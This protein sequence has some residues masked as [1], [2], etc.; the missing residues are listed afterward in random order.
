MNKD[1]ISVQPISSFN[2][3]EAMRK[4]RRLFSFTLELSARCNLNCRHCYLNVPENDLAAQDAELSFQEITALVDESSSLGAL[5]ALVTGGE[6]LLRHDFFDIYMYL[7][8]KGM[9][10]SVF[11]NATLFTKEH[12][13][14][15]TRYPPRDLDITVYGAT[16][17]TYERI[18]RKSGS[19]E[20]FKEGIA[21]L[22][23][24]NIKFNLKAM[25]LRSN[26]QEL[27]QITALCREYSKAPFRFDPFLHL[28]FDRDHLRNQ[29]IRNERLTPQEIG[30][31]ETLDSTRHTALKKECRRLQA[32]YPQER[33][34]DHLFRCGTGRGSLAI[35]YDGWCRMC[36]SL[37]HP[38]C[39]FDLRNH[40][41]TDVWEGCIPQAL[42]KRVQNQA[43]LA[44]CRNCTFRYLCSWCPAQSY[45]EAG[46]LDSL[47]PYL[48]DAAGK[49]SQSIMK[50]IPLPVSL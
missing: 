2:A 15:F 49:R 29:E 23:E 42:T 11:T 12:V 38:E 17:D 39:I 7:K 9:V 31:L 6:P 3:W 10:I 5:W 1:F 34:C 30:T 47:I 19:F 35:G 20:A 50:D 27:P 40:S 21:L 32:Q 26:I 8:R 37:C 4:R 36:L 48:C 25:A 28:R 45:L 41:L 22:L 14:L 16:K 43:L 13:H 44:Q 46:E 18:T 33:D 24:N